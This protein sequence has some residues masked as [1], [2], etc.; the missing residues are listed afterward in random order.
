M[1]TRQSQNTLSTCDCPRPSETAHI[2]WIGCIWWTDGIKYSLLWRMFKLGRTTYWRQSC[3]IPSSAAESPTRAPF[4]FCSW[5]Q[6]KQHKWN[7][8]LSFC[9]LYQWGSSR[10]C[11]RLSRRTQNC[12]SSLWQS[13]TCIARTG[14]KWRWLFQSRR[15]GVGTLDCGEYRLW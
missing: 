5:M 8:S 6:G 1:K 12:T 7:N 11:Q 9:P 13:D 10:F 3:K 14:P 2:Y 15:R 4:E